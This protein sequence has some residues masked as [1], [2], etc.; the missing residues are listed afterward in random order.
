MSIQLYRVVKQLIRSRLKV[1][2]CW[3]H[4]VYAD[5]ISFFVARKCQKIRKMMKIVNIEDENLHAF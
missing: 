2:K 4:L 3:D 5:F 1:K